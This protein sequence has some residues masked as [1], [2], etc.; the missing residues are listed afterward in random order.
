MS[1]VTGWSDA[2]YWQYIRSSLRRAWSRY[3]PKYEALAKSR[4]PSHRKGLKWEYQCKECSNWFKGTEVQVDHI[5]PAGSLRSFDE[6]G[7]FIDRLFCT[8]D[9]LQVLCKPCHALKTKSERNIEKGGK[10]EQL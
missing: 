2:R 3:P 1:R 10:N 5:L 6:C 4:R 9:N 7:I 8:S